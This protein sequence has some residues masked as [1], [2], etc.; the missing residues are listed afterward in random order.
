[1]TKKPAKSI[2][3]A[4]LLEIGAAQSSFFELRTRMQ[5][6]VDSHYPRLAWWKF[7]HNELKIRYGG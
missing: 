6:M 4:R 5:F 1:M 2:S 3:V 7:A